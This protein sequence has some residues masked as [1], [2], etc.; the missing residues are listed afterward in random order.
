[1]PKSIEELMEESERMEGEIDLAEK[2][3]LLKRAKEQYGE[4]GVKRL[5]RKNVQR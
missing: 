3:A 4:D 2:K 1:M 5:F